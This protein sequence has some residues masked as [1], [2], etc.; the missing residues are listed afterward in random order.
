MEEL[1]ESSLFFGFQSTYTRL[2]NT[3]L[4]LM[5]QRL[6]KIYLAASQANTD[7]QP[8]IYHTK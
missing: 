1:E 2:D 6:I 3:S 5:S 8:E 4:Y 7:K